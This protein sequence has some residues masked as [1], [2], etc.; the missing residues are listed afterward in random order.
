MSD[1][2]PDYT[3]GPYT[4]EGKHPWTI[5]CPTPV[6]GILGTVATVTYR[7]NAFLFHAAPDLIEALKELAFRAKAHGMNTD[8]ADAAIA[9]AEG[10][11]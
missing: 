7:P 4:I 8:D 11:S 10:R 1:T 5:K 6:S 2:M 3:A 9:K